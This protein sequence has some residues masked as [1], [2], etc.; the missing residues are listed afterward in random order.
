MM[1]AKIRK[2]LLENKHLLSCNYFAVIPPCSQSAMLA[3]NAKTGMRAA[4]LN[5]EN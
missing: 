5:V 3:K 1:T 4:E 2:T